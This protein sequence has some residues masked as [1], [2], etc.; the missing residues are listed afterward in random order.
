MIRFARV[1]RPGREGDG[2]PSSAKVKNGV[3]VPLLNTSYGGTALETVWRVISKA[4]GTPRA[5][6][7]AISDN[8]N[9]PGQIDVVNHWALA[10]LQVLGSTRTNSSNCS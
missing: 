7:T 1:M 3:A 6:A 8:C 5:V 10:V 2:S 4:E 9:Q